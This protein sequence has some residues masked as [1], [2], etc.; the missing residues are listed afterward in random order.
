M[1]AAR[2]TPHST[3]VRMKART[4]CAEPTREERAPRSCRHAKPKKTL[5]STRAQIR[6]AP[7]FQAIQSQRAALKIPSRIPAT[8][9]LAV[10]TVTVFDDAELK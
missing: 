1:R 5:D 2:P 10:C 6:P 3:K 9:K 8:R 7:V 4:G